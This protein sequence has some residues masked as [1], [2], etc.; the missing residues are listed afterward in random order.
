MQHNQ[1]ICR[2]LRPEFVVAD[3]LFAGRVEIP[4]RLGTCF[5]AHNGSDGEA[6]RHEQAMQAHTI[7][8]TLKS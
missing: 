8:V 5:L 2:T 6:Q 1:A 4:G 3:R 7:A